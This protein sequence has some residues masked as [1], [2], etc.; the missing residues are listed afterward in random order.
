[1]RKRAVIL[2][3]T[4]GELIDSVGLNSCRLVLLLNVGWKVDKSVGK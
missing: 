2:T 4:E 3:C 1:M